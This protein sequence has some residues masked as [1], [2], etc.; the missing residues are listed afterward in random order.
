[1][2]KLINPNLI[3]GTLLFL[4]SCATSMLPIKVTD[5]LPPLTKAKFISQSQAEEAAKTNRCKIFG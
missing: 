4:T 1:M 3:I 2:H 5:T